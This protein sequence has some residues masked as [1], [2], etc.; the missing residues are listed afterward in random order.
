MTQKMQTKW[1]TAKFYTKNTIGSKFTILRLQEST[2]CGAPK[3][4]KRAVH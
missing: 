3:M 1:K 4:Y 2:K